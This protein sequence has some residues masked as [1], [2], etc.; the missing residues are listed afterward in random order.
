MECR[1]DNH[2]GAIYA[3]NDGVL[4][5]K[6]SQFVM[7]SANGKGGAIYALSVSSDSVVQSC[8]I[9]CQA[10]GDGC[11]IYHKSSNKITLD[12]LKFMDCDAYGGDGWVVYSEAACV[13]SKFCNFSSETRSGAVGS[14]YTGHI[15]GG[16]FDMAYQLVK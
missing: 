7:C 1:T 12:G 2:G 16:C 8:F 4:S 10:K 6:S 5:V 13:T 9:G 15:Q 14:C 3:D 11:A